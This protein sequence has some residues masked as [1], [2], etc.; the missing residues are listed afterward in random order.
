MARSKITWASIHYCA[1]QISSRQTV[2]QIMRT[3]RSKGHTKFISHKS[4]AL[5]AR[6][7]CWCSARF[8][9]VFCLHACKAELQPSKNSHYWS[10][11][12]D[13]DYIM[14]REKRG[15]I[16][17][18]STPHIHHRHTHLPFWWFAQEKQGRICIYGLLGRLECLQCCLP[19]TT[20]LS[21]LVMI[22]FFVL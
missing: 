15:N 11:E 22:D 4:D 13:I 2:S 19:G 6:C 10:F 18:L 1:P 20:T 16:Q 21:Y 12:K 14:F 8:V 7:F 9:G 5:F 3:S 17:K